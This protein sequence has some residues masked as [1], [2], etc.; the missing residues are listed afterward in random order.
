ML[1]VCVNQALALAFGDTPPPA[2]VLTHLRNDGIL[3]ST[4]SSTPDSADYNNPPTSSQSQNKTFTPNYLGPEYEFARENPVFQ[5]QD[6]YENEN[7]DN[8]RDQAESEIKTRDL[9]YFPGFNENELVSE[10]SL[11]PEGA[12]DPAQQYSDLLNKMAQEEYDKIKKQKEKL[13]R[14]NSS[15]NPNLSNNPNNPNDPSP[16]GAGEGSEN[17]EHERD[18]D[19]EEDDDI[20][21]FHEKLG[22]K[23]KRGHLPSGM[24]AKTKLYSE[25]REGFLRYKDTRQPTQTADEKG[26]KIATKPWLKSD[27]SRDEAEYKGIQGEGLD[28]KNNET[29]QYQEEHADVFQGMAE[30]EA[31]VLRI[32]QAKGL[33][34][35]PWA[36][37]VPIQ[38]TGGVEGDADLGHQKADEFNEKLN[39]FFE[40]LPNPRQ[41]L[42]NA[43]K[44][45][46]KQRRKPSKRRRR[47]LSK[48]SQE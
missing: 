14:E 8:S 23:K 25:K 46:K 20:G 40:N 31:D 22:G 5:N 16:P 43:G 38:P 3:S 18:E 47:P 10:E 9:G 4:L 27:F 33:Q 39:D 19:E 45:R 41:L 48:K 2:H 15:Y 21:T 6:R 7:I 17:L 28:E 29:L 37:D 32:A 42:K 13:A 34:E 30:L 35:D 44:A 1:C 12:S 11:I 26:G 24:K 36:D